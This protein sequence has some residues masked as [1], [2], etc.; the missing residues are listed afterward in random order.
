MI[1]FLDCTKCWSNTG[2][3]WCGSGCAVW[4]HYLMNTKLIF[5][6]YLQCRLWLQNLY[7]LSNDRNKFKK[8]IWLIQLS[9][10]LVEFCAPLSWSFVYNRVAWLKDSSTQIDLFI[11]KCGSELPPFML[12]FLAQLSSGYFKYFFLFVLLSY[13]IYAG[14]IAT[15]L[16]HLRS[17]HTLNASC[18]GVWH[19]KRNYL[20]FYMSRY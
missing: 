12:K 9:A 13:C 16:P 6:N 11:S 10:S 1:T 3:F 15:M 19:Q 7:Y 4:N 5:Y 2:S 17:K 18:D 20:N 8:L 14:K